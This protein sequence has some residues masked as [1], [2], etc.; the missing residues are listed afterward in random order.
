MRQQHEQDRR[1]TATANAPAGEAHAFTVFD[2]YSGK[3]YAFW[4]TTDVA[5]AWAEPYGAR[6]EDLLALTVCDS[7][8]S[9]HDRRGI[10]VMRVN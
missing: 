10:A 7:W 3:V 4:V 6:H 9:H 2:C 8:R 1:P 5:I